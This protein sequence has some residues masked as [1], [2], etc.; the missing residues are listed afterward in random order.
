MGF[1]IIKIGKLSSLRY[2]KLRLN[3]KNLVILLC[4]K[5]TELL[6]ACSQIFLFPKHF[7]EKNFFK[8][9]LKMDTACYECSLSYREPGPADLVMFLHALRYTVN[10]I[11]KK[12]ILKKYDILK[13]YAILKNTPF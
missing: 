2:F 10:T 13:K 1:T 3:S 12:K 6:K 9:K 7:K 8:E 5:L 4:T 11:L